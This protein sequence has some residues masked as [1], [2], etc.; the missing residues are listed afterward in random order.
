MKKLLALIIAISLMSV[1]C[2]RVTT[3]VQEDD[4]KE[5]HENVEVIPTP[6]NPIEEPE[7]EGIPYIDENGEEST[8]PEIKPDD[9]PVEQ[10]E[11]FFPD[12][13]DGYEGL[14]ASFIK[15]SIAG[16]SVSEIKQVWGDGDMN[17]SSGTTAT[18]AYFA[19]E[20]DIVISYNPETDE[21]ID[22]E[23]IEN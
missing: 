22:V 17:Q 2:A 23:V 12:K 6:D 8:L 18:V 21:I 13:P 19:D 15:S 7:K 5:P 4:S 11:Y 1:G 3:P 16:M 20:R 9:K 14:D 10:P